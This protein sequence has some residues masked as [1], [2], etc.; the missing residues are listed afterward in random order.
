MAQPAYISISCLP[1]PTF[2]EGGYATFHAG[3]HH[4]N[5]NNLQYFIL[6]FMIKGKLFISE[7]DND[8]TV[9]P[10]EMFVLLPMHHHYSWHAV[11]EDTGY[12][13]LHFYVSGHWQQQATLV[14]MR[15]AIKVPTLHHYTPTETLYLAKH[16][17]MQHPDRLVQ[18]TEQIFKNSSATKEYGFWQAQQLF[19]DV[20]QEVQVQSQQDSA[21]VQLSGQIQRYLRDHFD[22]KI[23]NTTLSQEFHFHPNYL[24]RT[25]KATTGLTP[26]EF[27]RQYR[28]EEASKRLL[29]T[30]MLE[31][32]IAEA[33]G[34]QNIYYFSTV[35][36]QYTG[37]SPS[38]YRQANTR[39]IKA[40][41]EGLK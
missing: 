38:Q 15:S 36:K 37:L 6:M 11:T 27:L 10:G 1:L 24:I 9:E 35:F 41:K 29:N 32:E 20:L 16:A 39:R 12:Y 4:P 7:D 28:M 33:I 8:Y 26:T 34:F 5:R 13:W 18:M 25:L 31:T 14:P 2:I 22:E 19:I 21:M 17:K 40:D 23:T 30:N 3:D